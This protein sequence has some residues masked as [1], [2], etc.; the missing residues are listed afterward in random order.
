VLRDGEACEA[1]VVGIEVERSTSGGTVE[2]EYR[3]AFDVRSAARGA[4]RKSQ[5]HGPSPELAANTR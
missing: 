1:E 5:A 3:Y 2:P 4:G